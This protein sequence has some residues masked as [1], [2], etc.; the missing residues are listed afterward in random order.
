MPSIS[1]GK[2]A[3]ANVVYVDDLAAY[4]YT[5]FNDGEVVFTD[6]NVVDDVCSPLLRGADIDG[7]GD[8]LL[9]P[10][11]AWT[12]TCSQ[13][14]TVT[15][16]NTVT[17]E[18]LVGVDVLASD[19]TTERVRVIAPSFS[20][21]K[22]SSASSVPLG[23]SV[24]YTYE[25][26][27]SGQATID[28]FISALAMSDDKCAPVV[29]VSGDDGDNQLG[30]DLS[31]GTPETWTYECTTTL[32]DDTLNVVTVNGTDA[33]GNPVPETTDSVF[34]DVLF[35][36]AIA[37]D[38]TGPA[39]AALGD[40]VTYSFTV[41]NDDLAG[42]GSAISDVVVDD[43]VVGP[44][45]YISGDD[46]G[47]G[48]LEVGE[49]WLFQAG[50]TVTL[51]GPDPLLN[52]ATATGTD[53]DGEPAA[54][55]TDSHIT[56]IDY[57]PALS[58]A[59]SGPAIAALGETITYSF[60]VTND[61]AAGD[62]SP[63]ADVIVND[64][65]AGTAA[66]VSGDDD[67]DGLLDA[68]ET[69]LFEASSTISASDPDPLTN[70]VTV[71][72]TDADGDPVA[73][74]TDSHTTDLDFAPSISLV[75]S[76][77]SNADE[78]GSGDVTLG[79]TLTY[80]FVATNDGNLTL[81]G[82]TITD[83]LP[84]LSTLACSPAT[85]STLA[86][87][88]ILTCSAT[89]VVALAD[90]DS[91]QI[92]NTATVDATDAT[93]DPL[94]A[95]DAETVVVTQAPSATLAKSLDNNA[96]EDGSGTVSPGDTLTYSF[97]A[98]NDGN[99]TLTDV[100]VT[101]PMAGL[102]ALT[103]SLASPATL[104]P[105]EVMTCSATYVVT[106]ADVDAG[107]IQNTATLAG[108]DPAGSPV[109]DLSD[110][111]ADPTDNDSD[112]D[113]DPDDPTVVVLPQVPDIS[114]TKTVGLPIDTNGDGLVGGVGDEISYAFAVT[115]SGN[116][117]ITDVS[118]DDP[119]ASVVGGPIDTLVPGATDSTTF[120]ATYVITQADV[121]AGAVQNSATASADDPGGNSVSDLSDDPV[122]PTDADPDGDGDPDDPTVVVLSQLADITLTKSGGA[123]T[124]TNGDRVV[125]G[126]GDEIVYS[127]E[128]TNTGTVTLA[129]VIVTD[130]L[131]DVS[132][133]PIAALAPGATDSTIFTAAYVITQADVDAG[134]V[135]NTATVAGSDPGGD[136][137]T[138]A[139]DDP[140]DPTN[141]DPDADGD[142]DDPTVVTLVGAA[143]IDITKLS[144]VN[145]GPVR[146]GDTVTYTIEVENTGGVPIDNVVVS[147]VLP[148]GV[149]YVDGSSQL[150]LDTFTSGSLT[151]N[152][153]STDFDVN[154]ATQT[155]TLTT[156]DIPAGSILTGYELSATGLSLDWLS[157]IGLTAT[158]PGGVAYD[159]D[160]GSFGG[161]GPGSFGVSRGP[162]AF[163][164]GALGTY[165]FVW[166]DSFDGVA[167]ADN[168]VTAA[169]F[170]IGY[171]YPV[172]SGQ[173]AGAPP[174]LVT[175]ADNIDLQPG[176]TIVLTFDVVVDDPLSIVGDQ[177]ANTATATSS[178]TPPVSA[179]TIDLLENPPALSI[180]K[181]D[182]PGPALVGETMIYSID[183]INS[184]GAATDVV[185]TD[186]LPSNVTFVSADFVTGSGTCSSA[187]LDV[188]CVVGSMATGDNV[189]LEITVLVD[190]VTGS[191]TVPL[192]ASPTEVNQ[193]GASSGS[194]FRSG[195]WTGDSSSA[196][197][198]TVTA[199]TSDF[200]NG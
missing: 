175:E 116:V 31:T 78:D 124:D 16:R 82:V 137:V 138:D 89:Y 140:T 167:G 49:T 8:G 194:A 134:A 88:G 127:F 90:A 125:G 86:P 32:T 6:L 87:G 105:G 112:G 118:V 13:Q 39:S 141:T 129:D 110:D 147:D 102:S 17:A 60:E 179:T 45:A 189:S 176:Q 153:G 19:T 133:G 23:D 3:A 108:S 103:C 9:E 128:V 75:K 139:S 148:E 48:L 71:T 93:G 188:T 172:T 56:D 14:L 65:V 168:T 69:W 25:V 149:T 99:V 11:E 192:W 121:D 54:P 114:I 74:A 170:T 104:A 81:T 159:L 193:A 109:A 195:A 5:V 66:F 117:T 46:D 73:P 164:G 163:T 200:T 1:V 94:S 107:V 33:L 106:Q 186:A 113:G 191:Q 42:D 77:D 181:S 152:L 50:G 143:V 183:V 96:D 95:S 83:P 67:G 151:R 97:V 63:I 57:A 131:V 29:Y 72:A 123:L 177:L 30:F 12:Y 27:N 144:S 26:T 122:N 160:P 80:S 156:A 91:G 28:H 171:R 92:D 70:I 38:K 196:G 157:D 190:D 169:E 100:A 35:A 173:P 52:M 34:V 174:S 150:L 126:V 37:V 36:P 111:P 130:P 55:G 135:V 24:T 84:G 182:N 43:D 146:P 47:D 198:I 64:D 161:D 41:T 22:T 76:V 184:G 85:P 155:T 101:D 142:P 145:G 20:V 68:G 185:I 40:T 115:N 7:N 4:T 15:T 154:G 199:T 165:S 119:L 166:S 51:A 136:P 79:D 59:K 98:A 58:I 44:A 120:T 197:P 158:Y 21:D 62:G 2:V 132:G 10:G 178:G 180:V 61:T 187:G 18:G 53:R 162:E